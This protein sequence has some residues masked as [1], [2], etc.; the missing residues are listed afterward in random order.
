MEWVLYL[1]PGLTFI[2]IIGWVSGVGLVL[3]L[4]HLELA[5]AVHTD[6]RHR[7]EVL[8][9]VVRVDLHL[10]EL[11]CEQQLRQLLVTLPCLHTSYCRLE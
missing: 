11:A 8:R 2:L 1:R 10:D 6:H 4:Q 5:C 9:S 3:G 7:T